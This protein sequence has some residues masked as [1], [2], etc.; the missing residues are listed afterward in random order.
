[1]TSIY[2][3]KS[4]E[5]RRY[6]PQ[7]T[8]AIRL[9]RTLNIT[10]KIRKKMAVFLYVSPASR[11]DRYSH[12]NRWDWLR[13]VLSPKGQIFLRKLKI[14]EIICLSKNPI[15]LWECNDP[16]LYFST[17][18]TPL[19]TVFKGK[20]RINKTVTRLQPQTSSHSDWK[21]LEA[22]WI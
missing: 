18:A 15:F 12:L 14:R 1:M 7:K 13:C 2:Y 4:P 10:R 11:Q 16:Q 22:Q 8:M 6:V 19:L 20:M 21:F 17:I 9:N 3:F 5:L